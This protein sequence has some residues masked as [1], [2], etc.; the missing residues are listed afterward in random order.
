MDNF[1]NFNIGILT[2]D[3]YNHYYDN[4]ESKWTPIKPIIKDITIG[5]SQSFIITKIQ[6]LIQFATTIIFHHFQGLSL[7]DGF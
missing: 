6:F 3:K 1:L 7:D 5:K 4:I 2:R